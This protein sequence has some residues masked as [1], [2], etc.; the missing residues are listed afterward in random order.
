MV[1]CWI[2]TAKQSTEETKKEKKLETKIINR[3]TD[4]QNNLMLILAPSKDEKYVVDLEN[5]KKSLLEKLGVD[6]LEKAENLFD[7]LQKNYQELLTKIGEIEITQDYNLEEFKNWLLAKPERKGKVNGKTIS[8][9]YYNKMLRKRT[10]QEFL[11]D[12]KKREQEREKLKSK[13]LVKFLAMVEVFE[14]W[15]NE[16]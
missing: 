5:E 10:W 1:N 3:N 16:I 11:K 9:S 12:D 13:N 4:Y 14:T 15:L 7:H 2:H 8:K 6:N